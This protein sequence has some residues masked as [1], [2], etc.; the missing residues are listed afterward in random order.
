MIEDSNPSSRMMPG[1]GS[2]CIVI[3][4]P[5]A[6]REREQVVRDNIF[7][8]TASLLRIETNIIHQVIHIIHKNHNLK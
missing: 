6:I 3:H 5:R 2:F 7:F 8:L 1:D 4:R